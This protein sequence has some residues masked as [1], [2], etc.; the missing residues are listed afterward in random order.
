LLYTQVPLSGP[1]AGVLQAQLYLVQPSAARV[2]Q[3]RERPPQVAGR[4]VPEPTLPGVLPHHVGHRLG[5][6]P[7]TVGVSVLVDT[8][9]DAP[10]C[11][12]GLPRPFVDGRLAPGGHRHR[13]LPRQLA[14]RA[15]TLVDSR[16]GQAIGLKLDLGGLHE[17]FAQWG[18]IPARRARK[19][20]PCQAFHATML[21]V[22]HPKQKRRPRASRGVALSLTGLRWIPCKTLSNFPEPGSHSDQSRGSG[23]CQSRMA[24]CPRLA[25]RPGLY[26]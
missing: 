12:A 21:L 7:V 13:C 9:E 16:G 15:Q 20:S 1:D 3:L 11:D 22:P 19:N 10:L 25:R 24:R 18:D 26:R 4:Q 14:D 8:P 6:H 2:G 17:S 5:A 23:L